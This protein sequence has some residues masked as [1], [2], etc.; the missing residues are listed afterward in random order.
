MMEIVFYETKDGKKPV[1]DFLHSL[2]AKMRVKMVQ[3]I[4][5]LKVYGYEL[6]EPYSKPLEDGIF[7]LRA[8]TG[9]N[10]S[11]VLY[12]FVVDGRAVLTHGFL[13]KRQ[14]TPRRE[15]ERAKKYREDYLSRKAGNN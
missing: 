4:S 14:K 13:K 3:T 12:F 6:R 9:G 2:E 7:E 1:N 8:Q 5:M 15:I 11:R 10:A